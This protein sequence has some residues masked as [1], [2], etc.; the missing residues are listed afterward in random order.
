MESIGLG[1]QPIQKPTQSA[2]QAVG[3]AA[4]QLFATFGIVENTTTQCVVSLALSG[5]TCEEYDAA[6]GMALKMA[7]AADS[8]AGFTPAKDAKGRD[9]YGP[10]QSSMATQASWRRQVFGAARLNLQSIVS[11]P[12]SGIVNPDTYPVFSKAVNLARE[13]LKN[14]GVDWRGVPNEQQR[15]ARE[16]KKTGKAYADAREQAEKAHPMQPGETIGQWQ[17]RIS[18]IVED[19]LTMSAMEAREAEVAK[20]VKSIIDK[21]GQALALDVAAALVAYVEAQNNQEEAPM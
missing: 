7:A 15:A 11:I 20:I 14:A 6:E 9:K 19:I 4:R 5:M 2:G 12:D 8:A 18:P 21:H 16:A 1:L 13:Y 17:A 3:N 10:K